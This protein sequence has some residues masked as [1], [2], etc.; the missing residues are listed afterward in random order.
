MFDSLP[1]FNCHRFHCLFSALTAEP[2]RKFPCSQILVNHTLNENC[3]SFSLLNPFHKHLES[4]FAEQKFPTTCLDP[5]FSFLLLHMLETSQLLN[6]LCQMSYTSTLCYVLLTSGCSIDQT[7][8]KSP[9]S[10]Y[11][12]LSLC[13]A[14]ISST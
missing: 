4:I 7:C 9:I 1:E 13:M 14:S 10:L 8:T 12:V 2:R 6:I 5:S 3:F 11:I